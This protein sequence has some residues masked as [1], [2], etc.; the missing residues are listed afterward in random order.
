MNAICPGYTDTDIIRTAVSNIVEKTGRSETEALQ[1]F[2]RS[3]PQ[4]RLIQPDE[5]ADTVIWLCSDS[6]RSIT[7]QA[8]SVSGGET[9]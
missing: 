3:N 6:A 1:E 9:S 4:A 8:I 2:T 7:G 5:I